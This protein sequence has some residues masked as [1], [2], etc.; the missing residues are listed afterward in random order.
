MLGNTLAVLKCQLRDSSLFVSTVP[1]DSS[2]LGV[3]DHHSRC[4]LCND[5]RV[6]VSGEHF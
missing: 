4:C 2:T 6:V 3:S 5:S 1:V